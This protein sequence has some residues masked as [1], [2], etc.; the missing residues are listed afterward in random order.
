MSIGAFS[1]SRGIP[2]ILRVINTIGVRVKSIHL[3]FPNPL[4]ITVSLPSRANLPRISILP[5][6]GIIGV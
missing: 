1:E 5:F 2:N 3:I 4:R 6:L